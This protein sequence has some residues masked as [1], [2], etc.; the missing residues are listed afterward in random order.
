MRRKIVLHNIT[1]YRI[2]L[3]GDP[4]V[5]KTSLAIRHCKGT[6]TNTESFFATAGV[7]DFHAVTHDNGIKLQIVDQA[8]GHKLARISS[9][10]QYR[11]T[12]AYVIAFDQSNR[13][14]FERIGSYWM[15]NLNY[16][17]K[18]NTPVIIVAT[19]S[20]LSKKVVSNE[21]A[22]NLASYLSE[23]YSKN[24][25]YF[26]RTSAKNNVNVSSLFY[27]VVNSIRELMGCSPIYSTINQAK[28]ET[29]G[30]CIVFFNKAHQGKRDDQFFQCFRSTELTGS[31]TLAEIL[32]HAAKENN[33]SR[34]VCVDL[35]WMNEDGTITK[36]APQPVKD[37]DPSK[38]SSL[39][40]YLLKK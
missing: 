31:E 19:K 30:D 11:N 8:T 26:G 36:D 18:E 34:K 38:I 9:D 2:A 22:E 40:T 3:L 23:K 12:M 13:E 33:R 4:E 35:G 32:K 27:S 37:N 15:E 1:S 39:A 28:L 10:Y 16:Y 5:G 14:S 6:F 17:L 21:E 20:D 25:T 7:G 24:V 29:E